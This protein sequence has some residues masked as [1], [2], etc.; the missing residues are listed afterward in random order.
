MTDAS[1]PGSSPRTILLLI[2]AL[3]LG[4]M[5]LAGVLRFSGWRPASLQNKGEL[6]N[7]Y[8]D[9]R[10]HALTL[11]AGGVYRWQDSPRTWRIVVMPEQCD[12][13]R[14]A[15][16][17]RLLVTLDKVWR[18]L[19]PQA[20]RVHVVWAGAL[21]IATE[22]MPEVRAIHPD[23]RL[24]AALA[25]PAEGRGDPVWLIDPYGFVVM[26]YPSGFDPAGLRRDLARLLKVN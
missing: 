23:A 16:C 18:L 15:E 12:G 3:T 13:V 7:P 17:V 9:L 6:L 4:S 25:A 22:G 10:D 2:L 19:G 14:R 1:R 26:R 20:G 11:T 8:V 21:P 24:R 5:G